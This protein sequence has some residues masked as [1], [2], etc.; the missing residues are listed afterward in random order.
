MNTKEIIDFITN[1]IDIEYYSASTK[2]I[3]STLQ[4]CPVDNN[5]EIIKSN[6]L[7]IN[8]Y[9][10]T[11]T[12]K[13]TDV[14]YILT[15]NERSLREFIRQIPSTKKVELHFY[16]AYSSFISHEFNIDGYGLGMILGQKRYVHNKTQEQLFRDITSKKDSCIAENKKYLALNNR[17]KDNIIMIEGERIIKRAIL[18]NLFLKCIFYTDKCLDFVESMKDEITKQNIP[19]YKISDGLMSALSDSKPVPKILA[20][21]PNYVASEEEFIFDTKSQILIFDG[22]S[23]PNNLGMVLR[24]AD[25][26]ACDAIVLLSNSI[27]PYNKIVTRAARGAMGRVPV[28]YANNDLQLIKLLKTNDFKIISTSANATSKFYSDNLYTGKRAWVIGNETEG[29]RNKIIEQ[30][31]QLVKIPM[32]KGQSSYNIAIAASL[33]MYEASRSSLH[34][35][36]ELE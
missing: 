17:V 33:I 29:V 25:I 21:M 23:N 8:G 16:V 26:L 35:I 14:F 36:D 1:N 7:S 3:I 12:S 9:L 19:T 20:P 13:D 30:S 28:Y 18:D 24:T 10:I 6:I 11:D 34:E 27:H 15:Q 5:L 31:D 2:N 22:I 32:A 4:N